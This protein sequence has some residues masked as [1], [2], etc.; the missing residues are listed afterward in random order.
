MRAEE[1]N[2]AEAVFFAMR[3]RAHRDG[4]PPAG[5]AARAARRA[6]GPDALRAAEDDALAGGRRD[7]AAARSALAA[8]QSLPHATSTSVW[9]STSELAYPENLAWTFVNLHAIEPT[10]SGR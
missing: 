2:S 3:G 1:T 7:A 9:K 8:S 4:A 10:R 6:R 5:R